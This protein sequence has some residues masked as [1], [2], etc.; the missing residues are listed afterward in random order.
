MIVETVLL[1]LTAI[2]AAT[3]LWRHKIYN[4]TTYPGILAGIALNAGLDGWEGLTES[5]AGF[6][7][8]GFIM[9][10]CF[11]LFQLGGGDVKLMAMTGALLG[12]H[13]GIEVLLW[14]FTLGAIAGVALLIWRVGFVKLVRAVLQQLGYSLRLG[15]WLPLTEEERRQLQPPL[16]LGPAALLAAMIVVFRWIA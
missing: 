13:R 10:V 2:A 6:A 15:T 1:L 8:C 3:D 14:T 16:Y 12:P 9:L 4:W 11:V 7:L 5:L